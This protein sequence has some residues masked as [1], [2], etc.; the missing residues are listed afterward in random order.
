MRLI[1]VA[2]A[3]VLA[4]CREPQ[5]EPGLQALIGGRLEA[6]LDAEPVPYSVVVIAAGKIRAMGPQATVPVPK[7]AEAI[8]AK[9]KVIRPMPY[10]ARIEPGAPAN[11][12]LFDAETGA[13]AGVM[14]DGQ[15]VR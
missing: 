10:D 8:N 13:P 15:W 9:G 6:A 12:M 1:V 3:L 7:G 11:L 2:C 5:T 4:A 14:R